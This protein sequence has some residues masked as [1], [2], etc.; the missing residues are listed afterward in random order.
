MFK[1]FGPGPGQYGLVQQSIMV[2]QIGPDRGQNV[3]KRVDQGHDLNMFG[4]VGSVQSGFS[5]RYAD[6]IPDGDNCDR[7]TNI[8]YL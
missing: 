8:Y 1:M 6:P 5:V 2:D 3:R 7:F 4:P